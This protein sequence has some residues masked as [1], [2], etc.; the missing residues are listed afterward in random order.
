M[1]RK[2]FE[3]QALELIG[4]K[5]IGVSYYEIAYENELRLWNSDSRFDSLDYGL[6]LELSNGKSAGIIW[7]SEFYQ[8]GISIQKNS[9][10]EQLRGNRK[11]NA[12]TQSRWRN[13]INSEITG[14][15]IIWSWVKQSGLLKPKT[16]YPQ[17]LLLTFS[18]N[19]TVFISALEV[20]DTGHHGL[21]DNLTV[22]FSQAEAIKFG[23]GV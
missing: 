21:A 12:T 22:F 5:L 3:A 4:E 11:I 13:L 15:K 10:Q 16:H 19:E 7:G 17:D 14:V 8:Y 18:N 2:Q 23:V 20:T 6:D 9:L 1:N